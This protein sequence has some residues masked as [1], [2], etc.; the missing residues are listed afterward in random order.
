[1]TPTANGHS[2]IYDPAM[3]AEIFYNKTEAVSLA[4]AV[5]RLRP[6]RSSAEA[7]ITP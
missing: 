4:N 2:M 7:E 1:M 3:A 5:S 6:Q